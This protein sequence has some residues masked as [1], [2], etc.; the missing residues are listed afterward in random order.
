M[1]I[2]TKVL[3][4]I[5]EDRLGGVSVRILQTAKHLKEDGFTTIVAMPPAKDRKFADLLDDAGILYYQV[6]NFKRLPPNLKPLTLLRWVLYFLP[7]TISLMRLIKRTKVDIVHANGILC[8]QGALAA[9]LAGVKLV[10]HL[11]MEYPRLLKS[12]LLP[13]LY[14]LPD[15]IPVVAEVVGRYYFG[16]S[17]KLANKVNVLYEPVDPSKFH[18]GY[19][20]EEYRRDF[21]LKQK[22]RV[23]GIVG[24]INTQKGYEYFFPAAKMI[25]EAFPH[26]KFLVVGKRVETKEIYWQ[27]LQALIANLKIKDDIILTEGKD[28]IPQRMNVMDIFVSSSVKEGCPLVILEAMA[29]QKPVVATRVGGVPELVVDGENGI[30]VSPKDSKAIAEAVLYLLNN[31]ERAREMGMTGRRRAI[32][33]FNLER[34]VQGHE[35]MYKSILTPLKEKMS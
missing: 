29:C 5:Q 7:G 34:C 8:L 6:K 11:I 13:F 28:D 24:S 27:K 9:K 20:V 31:P 35:E 33:Y 26:T 21:E 2:E 1:Q 19:N 18:P 32:E 15:R 10:W 22:D 30:L 25:K 12:L 14:L 17:S 4:I 3:N 16:A 23:I